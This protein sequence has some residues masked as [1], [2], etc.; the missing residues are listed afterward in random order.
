[1]YFYSL[2]FFIIL[3]LQF[4]VYRTRV[5]QVFDGLC[6]A[7]EFSRSFT[8]RFDGVCTSEIYSGTVKFKISQSLAIDIKR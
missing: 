2:S 8:A 7:G 6:S 5:Q 4:T 3:K 1:V